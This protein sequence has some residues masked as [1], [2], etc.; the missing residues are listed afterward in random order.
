MKK[1]SLS[2]HLSITHFKVLETV[3]NL[4]AKKAFPTVDGLAKI[5]NGVID[6]E[7]K[8]F[9]DSSTFATLLSYHGRKL[10]ALVTNLVRRG[11]LTY[12]YDDAGDD[13]FIKMTALGRSSLFSFQNDRSR[14][15]KQ[16]DRKAERTILFK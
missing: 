6:S 14:P 5:L 1:R 2:F 9:V 12:E 3:D 16:R 15:Y 11:Y 13:K 8:F 4:N 7:T 10:T